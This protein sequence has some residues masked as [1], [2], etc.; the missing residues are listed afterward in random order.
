MNTFLLIDNYEDCTIG[1]I[2]TKMDYCEFEKELYDTKKEFSE[3]E[4][5][6]YDNYYEKI[7]GIMWEK[8][9]EFEVTY[10]NKKIYI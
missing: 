1:I 7:F 10:I 8:G 2:T 3:V 9:L 4:Y 6:D 5:Q